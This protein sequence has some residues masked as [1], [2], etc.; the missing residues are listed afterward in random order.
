M[1]YVVQASPFTKIFTREWATKCVEDPT[2]I[3][4]SSPKLFEVKVPRP[5]GGLKLTHLVPVHAATL[6]PRSQ[7]DEDGN[8]LGQT[9][10]VD[11][12]EMT[13][14]VEWLTG[15]RSEET[16]IYGVIAVAVGNSFESG[17]QDMMMLA[18]ESAQA[19][20]KQAM[21]AIAKKQ[22]KIQR[23]IAESLT[24]SLAEATKTANERVKRALSITHNNLL[25]SWE[26]LRADG[27][28]TYTPSVQEALGHFI[29]KAEVDRKI[30]LNKKL[31]NTVAEG[32]PGAQRA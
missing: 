24:K 6:I 21:D 1:T 3:E 22:A 20:S 32:I 25:K 7:K 17:L 2:L 10:T 26:A 4:K 29:I 5:C 30:E 12:D 23:E 31:Y 11:E 13:P 18:M 8:D 14:L 28:G 16:H 9:R 27:K 15:E 19:G